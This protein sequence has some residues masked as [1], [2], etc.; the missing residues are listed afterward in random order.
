MKFYIE[1]LQKVESD[2]KEFYKYAYKNNISKT[3][4]E[5]VYFHENMIGLLSFGKMLAFFEKLNKKFSIYS[6]NTTD[7]QSFEKTIYYAIDESGI[8][9]GYIFG[10]I[11][12]YVTNPL[13]HVDENHFYGRGSDYLSNGMKYI[14]GFVENWNG[15]KFSISLDEFNKIF[16]PLKFNKEHEFKITSDNILLLKKDNKSVVIPIIE[17]LQKEITEDYPENLKLNLRRDY[18]EFKYIIKT[19]RLKKEPVFKNYKG[20][21]DLEKFEITNWEFEEL[22]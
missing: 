21:I 8:I 1:S 9:Y 12:D 14:Y 3:N 6:Q 17:L 15:N 10:P 11:N 22:N 2:A 16:L 20:K 19:P 5:S 4:L 13:D 7:D 18:I